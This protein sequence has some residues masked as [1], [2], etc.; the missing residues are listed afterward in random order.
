MRDFGYLSYVIHDTDDDAV[1]LDE[2]TVDWTSRQLG[3][4]LDSVILFHHLDVNR[5]GVINEAI[6]M[7]WIE[8]FF[9]HNRE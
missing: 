1:S 8:K 9:D 2:F 5:D 4:A 3:T 6:D 7:P